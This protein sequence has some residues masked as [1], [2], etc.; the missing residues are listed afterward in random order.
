MESLLIQALIMD[1]QNSKGIQ[2]H[3]AIRILSGFAQ[4]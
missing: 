2:I 3:L 4:V 1:D